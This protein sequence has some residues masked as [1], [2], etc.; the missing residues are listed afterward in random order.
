MRYLNNKSPLFW[1]I[2]YFLIIPV[3]ATVFLF[4]PT[5]T[6]S[7]NSDL[8]NW[9]EC[10]YFSMVTITTLGFGDIAPIT[11]LGRLLVAIETVSG[12]LFIGLFL[13]ALSLQQSKIISEEEKKKH[14]E[15]IREKERAKLL[16][17]Y[18]LIEPIIN[19]FIIAIYEITTPL[20]NRNFAKIIINENF[21]FNDMS[22]LYYQSLKLASNPT[23]TVIHNYYEVQNKLCHNIERL[24]L[25]IDLSYWKNIEIACLNFLQK[26]NELDYSDSILG[27]FKIKLGNQKAID[28]YS[29]VIKKYTG[30][31]QYRQSNTMNQFIALYELI[32]YNIRFIEEIR[33][34]FDK[35]KA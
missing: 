29:A 34:D 18:K 21:H 35:I 26:C 15:N 4:L 5:E 3:F 12:V 13:N 30:K 6:W 32:K 11:T 28:Y 19:E 33:Q 31:L 22:D 8:E 25:E 7:A 10:L 16:R 1:G 14:E 27:N 2:L 20:S 17:H 23:K 24:L 9:W